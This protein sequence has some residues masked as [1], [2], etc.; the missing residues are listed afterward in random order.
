[1]VDM[2][3]LRGMFRSGVNTWLIAGLVVANGLLLM[4][5]YKVMHVFGGAILFCLIPGLALVYVLFRRSDQMGLLPMLVLG[6][7]TSYVLSNLTVL[8]LCSLPGGINRDQLV[9][10]L[11][12]IC[13]AMI[14]ART[15]LPDSRDANGLRRGL[16]GSW[17]YVAALLVV[18]CVFRFVGLG[19]GEYSAMDELFIISFVVD[20]IAGK[21]SLLGFPTKGPGQLTTLLPFV[22]WNNGFDE[23]FL[24]LPFALASVVSVIGLYLLGREM[25]SDRVGFL[26]GLLLS[27]QGG[28]LAVSRFAQFQGIVVLMAVSAMYSF[29]RALNAEQETDRHRYLILGSAFFAFGCLTHHGGIMVAPALGVVYFSQRRS[30]WRRELFIVTV[31]AVIAFAIIAPFYVRFIFFERSHYVLDTRLGWNEG[32]YN[33]VQVLMSFMFFRNSVY[34]VAFMWLALLGALAVIWRQWGSSQRAALVA[35]LSLVVGLLVSLFFRESVQVGTVNWAFIFFL[36]MLCLL[37]L[38][39]GS[40]VGQRAVWMW[41]LTGF[42]ALAFFVKLP[43]TH[44]YVVAAPW[45]LLGGLVVDKGLSLMEKRSSWSTTRWGVWLALGLFVVLST[46]FLYMFFLQQVPEYART[47]PKYRSTLYWL[48]YHELPAEGVLFYGT[49]G[50]TG[51]KVIG[52]LYR[53]GILRGHLRLSSEGYSAQMVSEW[54]LGHKREI[55][56]NSRY[57]VYTGFGEGAYTQEAIEQWYDLMGR[58][59][60]HGV[61]KLW[62]YERK[63]ITLGEPVIDYAFEEYEALYDSLVSLDEQLRFGEIGVDSKT[64][65]RAAAVVEETS[66]PGDEIVF[67]EREQVGVFS[68]HYAGDLPYHIPEQALSPEGLGKILKER[69]GSGKVYV[70]LWASEDGD[71]RAQWDAWLDQTEGVREK[72]W[73]GNVGLAI[74]DGAGEVGLHLLEGSWL[75]ES[76]GLLGYEVGYSEADG[77]VE[78]LLYWAMEEYVWR[79]YTVFTHLLDDEGSMVGQKDNQPLGGMLPTSVWRTDMVVRD[80]YE[81]PLEIGAASGEYWIEV[82]MY[83]AGSGMRLPTQGEGSLPDGRVR[84]PIPLEID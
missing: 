44:W 45:V 54:Y 62:I 9:I 49:P 76:I 80:E 70:V 34:Y 69:E 58:V 40:D 82:G 81:I 15:L 1:M 66:E 41:F 47:F 30:S 13:V 68:Y 32:V 17:V 20:V 8:V 14:I 52:V 61:P 6:V 18:S 67:T 43:F 29:V 11:D 22:L 50:Q 42:I 57:I 36:P 79:D 26:A 84:L 63:D 25:F 64:Y 10:A 65:Y 59:L 48:P 35:S 4:P 78:L 72:A 12:F 7:A 3:R 56:D 21:A 46:G 75:G 5:G 33:N 28:Y 60:V 24:R 27:L 2:G 83:D 39:T 23:F 73:H 19:Y 71:E 38:R 77:V 16:G 55:D 74:Y 37:V 53:L 31:C 51:Q